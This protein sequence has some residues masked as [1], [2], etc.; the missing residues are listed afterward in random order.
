MRRRKRPTTDLSGRDSFHVLASN[1]AQLAV[2]AAAPHALLVAQRVA[3]KSK[4]GIVLTVDRHSL[5]GPSV[6]VYRVTRT[7]AG[8]VF[9]LTLNPVD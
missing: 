9:T 8:A 5:F 7:E 3:E 6:P 1:G 2:K 4:D